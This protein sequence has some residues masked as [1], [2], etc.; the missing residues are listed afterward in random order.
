MIQVVSNIGPF[1]KKYKLYV[2]ILMIT[3]LV[4]FVLL[5][6]DVSSSLKYEFGNKQE[7]KLDMHLLNPA[8]K[9]LSTDSSNKLYLKVVVRDALG[10]PVPKALVQFA[11]PRGSITPAEIRTDRQG[12]AV[13]YYSPDEVNGTAVNSDQKV[14]ITSNLKG[15]PAASSVEVDLINVPVVFVHGYQASGAL[16]DNMKE[17]LENKG[18]RCSAVNY[19]SEEGVAMGSDQLNSF[20]QQLKL[21]YLAEG[22]Q[23]GKFDMIAH[24]M[25]G[26]VARYYSC[27]E[28]YIRN[29][30]I[31]KMIF[32]AVPHKGSHWASLGLQYYDDRA[33]HDLIPDSE[34]LSK[35]FPV[36]LNK[37]LNS[38]IQVGSIIGQY[39]EVVSLESADLSEW[40]IKTEIFNVGE[41]NFTVD[42]LLNGNIVEAANH[43]TILSNRKV[44]ERIEQML[45][46]KLPYPEIK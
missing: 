1:A 41:S 30:D 32:L 13:V 29:Q 31:R 7:M 25:G 22:I 28:A 27:S 3:A 10:Y 23:V 37:G 19:K 39:D 18:I 15:Q 9:V 34:L 6:D 44:F 2:L 24:S 8:V 14:K 35:T 40:N 43:K 26:L 4:V 12:E 36:M 42:K 45:E 17:F 20:M 33:I 46:S 5:S 11:V 38:T 16:F 21:D